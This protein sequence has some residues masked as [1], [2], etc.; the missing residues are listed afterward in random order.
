M[1]KHAGS[2]RVSGPTKSAGLAALAMALLVAAPASAQPDDP[3]ARATFSGG[4]VA[5]GVGY[6]WG[7]GVLHFDGRSYRFR[8]RGLSVTDVGVNHI[9][10]VG[11]VYNLQ[12]A[13]DFEGNYVAAS[14]GTTLANG[15]LAATLENQ[16]G[17]VIRFHSTTQGLRLNLSANG[18]YVHFR[19][20]AHDDD[21]AE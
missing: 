14:A 21:E 19:G 11:E 7:A 3:S 13:E 18:V 20:R 16:N 2:R 5:A 10:G 6:T 17:V 8:V 4:A 12:R 15:G 1:F 9:E